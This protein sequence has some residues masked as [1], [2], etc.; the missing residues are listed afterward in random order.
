MSGQCA[1]N[2]LRSPKFIYIRII[3]SVEPISDSCKSLRDFFASD[4]TCFCPAQ[5]IDID[6]Y[7]MSSVKSK[8]EEMLKCHKRAKTMHNLPDKR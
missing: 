8:S 1:T 5:R 6:Q 3:S 2:A 4:P 7:V